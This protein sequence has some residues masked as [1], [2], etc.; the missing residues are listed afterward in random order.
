M[1]TSVTQALTRTAVL[2]KHLMACLRR[3][4]SPPGFRKLSKQNLKVL[5]MCASVLSCA[6]T[7]FLCFRIE[8]PIRRFH[9]EYSHR[10]IYHKEIHASVYHKLPKKNL[11]K[12]STVTEDTMYAF[13]KEIYDAIGKTELQQYIRFTKFN[14]KFKFIM[15]K[16]KVAKPP[17]GYNYH[18][19]ALSSTDILIEERNGKTPTEARKM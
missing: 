16:I 18:V 19:K 3:L 11:R 12:C 8:S 2:H 7:L 17:A 5:F 1:T 9:K 4:Y 15:N 6:F 14:P 10:N 13:G